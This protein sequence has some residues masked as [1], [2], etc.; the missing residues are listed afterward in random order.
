MLFP[1][2]FPLKF[3]PHFVPFPTCPFPY[4]FPSEFP[5]TLPHSQLAFP[6]TISPQNFPLLF[7]LLPPYP[8][9]SP[10]SLRS[11]PFTSAP[12]FLLLFPLKTSPHFT[13]I[14]CLPSPLPSLVKISPYSYY[15]HFPHISLSPF[16]LSPHHVPFFPFTISPHLTPYPTLFSLTSQKISPHFPFF[17]PHIPLTLFTASPHHAPSST[18]STGRRDSCSGGGG[19]GGGRQQQEGGGG[20]PV[21]PEARLDEQSASSS[22]KAPSSLYRQ[23]DTDRDG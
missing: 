20:L 15:P 19:C 16:T 7:L 23:T 17:T 11:L 9:H 14:P 18:G 1:L 5:L 6:L 22:G 3:S 13:F 4:H 2:P 8:S 10:L 21:C 12:P